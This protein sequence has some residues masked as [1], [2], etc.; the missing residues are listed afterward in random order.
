ML[1]GRQ[2]GR[3]HSA[4]LDG[5]IETYGL[6]YSA[7]LDGDLQLSALLSTIDFQ[8]ANYIG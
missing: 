6:I 3:G 7:L 4:L 1:P 8:D 2:V 5:F